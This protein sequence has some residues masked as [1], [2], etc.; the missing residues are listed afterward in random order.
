MSDLEDHG[1]QVDVWRGQR[2]YVNK[3]GAERDSKHTQYV[4]LKTLDIFQKDG[5]TLTQI[6]SIAPSIL[7]AVGIGQ[8][9]ESPVVHE[10]NSADQKTDRVDET[11]QNDVVCLPWEHDDLYYRMPG[12]TISNIKH[13]GTSFSKGVQ[14]ERMTAGMLS[15]LPTGY[16]L[17]SVPMRE[18]KDIDHLYID[19][20]GIYAINTKTRIA[21]TSRTDI[22]KSVKSIIADAEYISSRFTDLMGVS[23]TVEPLIALWAENDELSSE[24]ST[25][26]LGK[27]LHDYLMNNTAEMTYSRRLIEQ[28]F[29]YARQE[30]TWKDFDVYV[31]PIDQLLG[32]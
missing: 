27:D 16:V 6:G 31:D 29:M 5:N 30:Q 18:T 26:V 32:D 17:H 13:N 15:K 20:N 11:E 1:Y 14:G 9:V 23:I 3:I 7:S 25:V 12:E 28:L 19:A 22:A 24:F 4:D 10:S 21:S 2:L 8:A